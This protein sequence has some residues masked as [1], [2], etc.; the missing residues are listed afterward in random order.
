MSEMKSY[1][2]GVRPWL[3]DSGSLM[4]FQLVATAVGMVT[5]LLIAHSLGRHDF[6]SF[7]AVLAIAQAASLFL[8][9][10]L[11]TFLL[12]EVSQEHPVGRRLDADLIPTVLLIE[13]RLIAATLPC[14]SVA[15]FLLTGKT[16]LA[17]LAAM[18][19]G[20]V[21][22]LALAVSIESYYRAHRRVERVG[23]AS[24]VEKFGA[25]IA[26][27]IIVGTGH[28]G[29]LLVGAALVFSASARLVFDISTL[30]SDL[31]LRRREP[32]SLGADLQLLRRAS[33][34]VATS[35]VLVMIPRLAVT[36]VAVVSATAAAYFALGDRLISSVVV[37]C[38]S[39]SETL[40]PHLARGTLNARRV[41]AIQFGAGAVG[42]AVIAVVAR[43]VLAIAF[44][45][46][47][48][49]AV[50]T[51]R[52]MA[53][54]IPF[55][56]LANGYLVQAYSRGLESRTP[57]FS[58]AATVIGM[59]AIVVGAVVWGSTG[60]AVGYVLRQILFCGSLGWLLRRRPRAFTDAHL[61][62]PRGKTS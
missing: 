7:A 5:F 18:L 28:H 32:F 10:G 25:L 45:S 39:L 44:G 22:L 48:S 2:S 42:C 23:A 49:V 17:L 36:A 37:Y 35:V 20:Y 54:S 62:V 33:P 60:A 34:F 24:L 31:A 56:F 52:I 1:S 38:A 9:A 53:L 27:V 12:R 41:F 57:V 61:I 46:A 43:P 55:T 21:G 19:I 8:D 40:Y 6:G 14:V 29:V 3:R 15:G 58:L 47:D 16:S 11:G 30:P 13:I 26:M 59:G 4:G 51:V 50:N